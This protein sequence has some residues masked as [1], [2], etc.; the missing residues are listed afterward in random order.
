MNYAGGKIVVA[1]QIADEMLKHIDKNNIQF[2]SYI[3]PFLGAGSVF[4]EMSKSLGDGVKYYGSDMSNDIMLMWYHIL[5]IYSGEEE[6]LTGLD[7]GKNEYLK[8]INKKPSAR[9][10]VL[11]MAYGYRGK[12]FGSYN[13]NEKGRKKNRSAQAQYERQIEK[14]KYMKD[15]VLSEGDYKQYTHVRNAVIYLDPPYRNTSCSFY[16]SFDNQVRGKGKLSKF[17]SD[18]FWD[19]IRFMSERNTVFVSERT[20]PEDFEE[21][22]V[23]RKGKEKLFAIKKG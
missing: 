6:M 11:G 7:M 15:A 2:D 4:A 18:A 5:K 17:D 9:R 16:K 22:G 12:I 19:W 20:A 1:K 8:E 14:S 10:T 21:L 23:W 3:E 13:E